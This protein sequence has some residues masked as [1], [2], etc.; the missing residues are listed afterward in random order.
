MATATNT[1]LEDIMLFSEVLLE[2]DKV[3]Y[4]RQQLRRALV[5]APE[6]PRLLSLFAQSYL[7]SGPFYNP[8]YAKQLATQACQS[9]GWES[10]RE[11]HI[12]ADSYFH[13]GDKVFALLVASKAKQVGNKLLGAYRGVKTLDKL[14]EDLSAGTQ[15]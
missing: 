12:L 11:M 14:I 9:S 6:H 4:A 15:A 7:K 5:V 1:S 3:A 10:P 2:E 8:E 13:E